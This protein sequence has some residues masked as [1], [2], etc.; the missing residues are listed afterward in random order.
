[1]FTH[2]ASLNHVA[3]LPQAG[4][5]ALA[6][7]FSPILATETQASTK[8]FLVAQKSISAP[9]GFSG[10]C[11]KYSWVCEKTGR[12]ALSDR[13]TFSLAKQVNRTVNRQVPEIEDQDQYGR[14][15]HWALPTRR[16]GDCEDLVLLKKK[17]LLAQGVPS[18]KLLIATVLDKKMRSHAVLVLRTSSGDMVLDNLTGKML[19]WQKTGYTFLKLQNPKSLSRWDAV[20]AGGV[21]SDSPTASR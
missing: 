5:L 8:P 4:L 2:A 1:M 11:R 18:E 10:I 16:G 20:L 9:S 15:E 21:I 14:A 7:L 19:P 3:R 17:M 6:L 12:S 13:A